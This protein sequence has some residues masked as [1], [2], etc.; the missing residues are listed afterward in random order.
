[1]YTFVTQFAIRCTMNITPAA[2]CNCK[3]ILVLQCAIVFTHFCCS[4]HPLVHC[5]SQ[6]CNVHL[7]SAA[8]IWTYS[9]TAS[10]NLYIAMSCLQLY[11]YIYVAVC[12]CMYSAHFYVAV[13]NCL[14]IA[15]F[16]AAVCIWMYTI[17]PL[18]ANIYTS[19]CQNV[20][21]NV[22]LNPAH[23]SCM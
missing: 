13:C 15:Y 9:C 5:A 18:R 8:C 23:C 20:K 6:C 12:N 16:C 4:V 10:C 7:C 19:L 17:V 3:H 21:W 14:R 1:M 22:H 11:V 2:T